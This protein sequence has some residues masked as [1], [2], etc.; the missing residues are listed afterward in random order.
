MVP[1]TKGGVL[2]PKKEIAQTEPKLQP[3][4]LNYQTA[5]RT[6]DDFLRSPVKMKMKRADPLYYSWLLVMTA[7]LLLTEDCFMTA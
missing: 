2:M 4:N 1:C 5:K 7:R 6:P 3:H